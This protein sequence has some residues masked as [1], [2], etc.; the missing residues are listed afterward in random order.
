MSSGAVGVG[1]EVSPR[2]D[3][4]V[5]DCPGVSARI[6]DVHLVGRIGRD[7]AAAHDIHLPVEVQRSRL[8]CSPRYCCDRANGVGRRI[9]AERVGGVHHWPPWKSDAPPT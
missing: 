8:S 4:W 3:E 7:S 6:V 1:G 9:E 5:A 2:I